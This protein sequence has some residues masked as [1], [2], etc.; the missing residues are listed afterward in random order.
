M[1]TIKYR[2]TSYYDTQSEETCY[3][4]EEEYLD[5]GYLNLGK[6]MMTPQYANIKTLII[7]NNNLKELPVSNLDN[8]RVLDCSYN[9]LTV[10]PFYPQLREL[11][12]KANSVNNLQNYSESK[13]IILDCGQNSYIN[14]DYSLPLLKHLYCSE[15]N[16]S[17]IESNNF[18]SLEILDCS[19]NLM[20]DIETFD[21]LIELYAKNNN[22]KKISIMNNL[23]RMNVDDN[24]LESIDVYNKLQIL[25][26]NNNYLTSLPLFPQLTKL[27][28]RYNKIKSI[29]S[30]PKLQFAE[31]AYNQITSV[32][33]LNQIQ[34][35]SIYENPLKNLDNLYHHIKEIEI[36]YNTYK[37]AYAWLCDKIKYINIQVNPHKLDRKLYELKQ[38]LSDNSLDIIRK[39]FMEIEF[40]DRNEM[41]R[42]L[43]LQIYCDKYNLNPS[44][45]INE[46]EDF[47]KL[48]YIIK[49]LYESLLIISLSFCT[50]ID[51]TSEFV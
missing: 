22:I 5:L 37:H 17:K 47:Q 3:D 7:N 20:T 35:L 12:F 2:S 19:Y 36:N 45:N 6:W 26:I 9:N 46:K 44:V 23:I 49:E 8:L 18:P 48:F 50:Q 24:Y 34:Y 42:F 33:I 13:L 21:N 25:C 10:I 30:M 41:L 29:E 16:I 38:F 51:Q 43:V 27:I 11:N 31:L 39:S 40:V 4:D 15:S 28:A 32:P 14:I 1:S